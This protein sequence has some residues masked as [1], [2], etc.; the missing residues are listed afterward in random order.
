MWLQTISNDLIA[1]KSWSRQALL[2]SYCFKFSKSQSFTKCEQIFTS[3][4]NTY[5]EIGKLHD[6]TSSA[7]I[8][9]VILD[10]WYI[11]PSDI[12]QWPTVMTTLGKMFG[13][14]NISIST[15]FTKTAIDAV[16]DLPVI[17]VQQTNKFLHLILL[18]GNN[19]HN[20]LFIFNIAFH[21]TEGY[22]VSTQFS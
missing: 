5:T 15:G 3:H 16:L 17:Y 19:T 8:H 12:S 7:C 18:T 4:K 21:F 1:T 9:R 14:R 10:K 20:S 22:T 11:D 13:C 6:N 2:C